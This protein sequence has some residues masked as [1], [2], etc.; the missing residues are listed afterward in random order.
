MKHVFLIM[1]IF[2]ISIMGRTQVI[3]SAKIAQIE[4][5]LHSDMETFSAKS[6]QVFIM[7]TE[8]GQIFATKCN[9]LI[10]RHSSALVRM[11]NLL[12]ALETGK[13]SL[14]DIVNTK[15]G[16]LKHKDYML[17][18]HNWHRGGYGKISV[19]RGFEVGS[20]IS[21]YKTIRAAWDN[22]TI[23]F[24]AALENLGYGLPY[25]MDS[26]ELLKPEFYENGICAVI[27]PLQTL[28]FF[29]AIANDGKMLQPLVNNDEIVVVKEQIASKESIARIQD[30]L[31]S[32]VTEGLGRK[33][34]SIKVK[35]A[36]MAGTAI[37][38]DGSYRLEFCGYFPFNNPQ[39]TV[40]VVLNK[41]ELPASSGGMSGVIFKKIADLLSE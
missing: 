29:N 37:E 22:D 34:N 12:A 10:V 1:C 38:E 28:T 33:S 5:V 11:P 35:V 41:D 19:K 13:V 23:A 31:R 26:V 9:S 27:T 18:D 15:R 30:V 20:V 39:Y 25:R 7:R 16:V 4:A 17:R 21:N 14:D 24:Y 8:T 36:G 2:P 40:L 6:G 32:F 3:D